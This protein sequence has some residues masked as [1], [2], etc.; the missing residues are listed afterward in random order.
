VTNRLASIVE[1][2]DHYLPS[3][4]TPCLVCPSLVLLLV[5]VM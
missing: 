1:I 2:L 5:V 3:N 4:T